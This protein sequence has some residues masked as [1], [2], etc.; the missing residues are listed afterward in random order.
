MIGSLAN[1]RNGALPSKYYC[2]KKRFRR[3]FNQSR[4]RDR[5]TYPTQIQNGERRG[6]L[7]GEE[8]FCFLLVFIGAI[9]FAS[10]KCPGSRKTYAYTTVCANR[11]RVQVDGGINGVML[12]R[13]GK[14][15]RTCISCQSVVYL[16]PREAT[17]SSPAPLFS[18]TSC[19]RC[20]R[21]IY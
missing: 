4:G 5:R 10:D 20:Y 11:V 12:R 15:Y 2:E 3:I 16:A 17:T 7:K 21:D 6:N 19:H 18:N 1:R 9:G 13:G 14:C 8:L